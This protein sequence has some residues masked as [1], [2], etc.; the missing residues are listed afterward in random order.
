ME[1]TTWEGYLRDTG[2]NQAQGVRKIGIFEIVSCNREEYFK[3]DDYGETE[4]AN[5]GGMYIQSIGDTDDK[6]IDY[7]RSWNWMRNTTSK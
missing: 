2:G 6:T 5:W 7:E 4:I 3:K 1:K